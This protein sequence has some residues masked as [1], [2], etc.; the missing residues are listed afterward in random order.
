MRK[1]DGTGRITVD[2]QV[3]NKV[4]PPIHTVVPSVVDLMDRLSN[5][6]GTYHFV[7]DL[8]NAFS[9]LILH[10]RIKISLP[11]HERANNGHLQCSLQGTCKA[12]TSVTGFWQKT[13][14]S[15]HSL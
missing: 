5:E 1:L 14:L 11:L 2:Y 13:W 12:Q 8:E 4:I 10:Q 15:G 6:L 3:L 9:P 7:A